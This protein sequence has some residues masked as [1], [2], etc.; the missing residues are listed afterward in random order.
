MGQKEIEKENKKEIEKEK[1]KEIIEEKDE[2][3]ISILTKE[4]EILKKQ[5]ESMNSG[6]KSNN[7]D[8]LLSMLEVLNMQRNKI[9]SIKKGNLYYIIIYLFLDRKYKNDKRKR[10]FNENFKR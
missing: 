4:N 10:S 3:M 9:L 5:L 1:E 7:Y 2:H 8:T 6:N